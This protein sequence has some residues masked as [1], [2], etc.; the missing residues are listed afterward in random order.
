MVPRFQAEPVAARST[1][2]ASFA[3]VTAFDTDDDLVLVDTG[4]FLHAS[5]PAPR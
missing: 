3:N 2:V 4:S 1:S 5:A